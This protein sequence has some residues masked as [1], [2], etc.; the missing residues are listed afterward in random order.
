[1]AFKVITTDRLYIKVA[2]QL[3]QLI[4]DGT[5]KTG[6]RFPAER[7]LAE[8]LGVSRPTIR[9]AMVA[10]ELAGLIEIRTGSGIYV[11][12]TPVEEQTEL[13]QD[14]I[15]PFEILEM[16]Y[17]LESEICA[18]AARRITDDQLQELEDILQEMEGALSDGKACEEADNKFHLIIAQASQNTAMYES[19]KWLW[20]LRNREY[21]NTA[22]FEKIRDEGIL[23][24]IEEHRKILSAL[25]NRD[26]ERARLAMKNHIDSATENAAK[27]F[28]HE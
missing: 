3:R 10:L 15:G 2:D 20:N 9:E 6:D 23:P 28:D 22:F 7:T 17:V 5:F 12:D 4:E 24:S 18:L 19:V 1:M 21:K 16:R 8:K 27:H 13:S 11:A 26:G 14:G 25:K